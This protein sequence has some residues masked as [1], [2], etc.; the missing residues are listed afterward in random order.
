[1]NGLD[2]IKQE[3]LS[4]GA[5]DRVRSIK[6]L[7]GMIKL[8]YSPQGREFC[9]KM[10]YPS[11]K[12]FREHKDVYNQI[13]GIYI[14]MG[15]VFSISPTSLAVGNTHLHLACISPTF[16]Y[17]SI[18]THGAVVDIFAANY[19]VVTATNIGGEF[20]VKADNTCIISIEDK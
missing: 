17:K 1:M 9:Q 7:E 11:L 4:L 2:L 20:N 10:R 16:L 18:A 19:A 6:T 5:C 15:D 12:H 8:F 14:D 13:P 3:A